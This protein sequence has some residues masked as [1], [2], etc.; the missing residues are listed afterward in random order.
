MSLSKQELEKQ[1]DY[2]FNETYDIKTGYVIPTIGDLPLGNSGKEVELA[3][4]FIDLRESTRIVKALQ[5]PTSAKMYK[6][7]LWG[8]SKISR[9]HGGEVRSFNGDGVLVMFAGAGKEESATKTALRLSYFVKEILKP[10]I[11]KYI[12]NSIKLADVDLNF[13]IGVDCGTVLVVAGGI[14]G[15]DNNDLVWVG[16]ATNMAVKLSSKS[17]DYLKENFHVFISEAV[18]KALPQNLQ[19]YKT[20]GGLPISTPIWVKKLGGLLPMTALGTTDGS[21]YYTTTRYMP[22][23]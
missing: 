16:N 15:T 9:E 22:I 13:G 17:K 14:R 7:F 18:Y 6:T 21:S 20:I 3:I 2:F 11:Q 4:L 10:R 1:A 5:R 19:F 12:S 23:K 8:V